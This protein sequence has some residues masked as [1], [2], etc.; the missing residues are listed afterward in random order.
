M[1]KCRQRNGR[2]SSYAAAERVT[3]R[4]KGLDLS[5][6]SKAKATDGG[7]KAIEKRLAERQNDGS[8]SVR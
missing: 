8:D 6:V 2:F 4:V 7:L 5:K 1:A 3:G